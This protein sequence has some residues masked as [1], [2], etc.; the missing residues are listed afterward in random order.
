MVVEQKSLNKWQFIWK[1]KTYYLCSCSYALSL[2][3]QQAIINQS[4]NPPGL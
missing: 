3:Y 1:V 4:W 2:P